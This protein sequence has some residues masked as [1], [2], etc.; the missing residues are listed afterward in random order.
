MS[1]TLPI[2][3]TC[4][5]ALHI[6]LLTRRYHCS[7]QPPLLTSLFLPVNKV[8]HPNCRITL[9]LI[10]RIMWITIKLTEVRPHEFLLLTDEWAFCFC[11][12]S[13][14]ELLL[15]ILDV[16]STFGREEIWLLSSMTL[17]GGWTTLSL[18]S[19]VV[20]EIL[21]LTYG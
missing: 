3:S 13:V 18:S 8:F 16:S 7:S 9:I 19:H 11:I 17:A 20:L 5:V 6:R 14:D 21:L 2:H 15:C 10:H 4:P 1:I 12:W